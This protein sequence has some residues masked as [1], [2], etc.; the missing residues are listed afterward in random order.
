MSTAS[1]SNIWADSPWKSIT[2]GGFP[3][4]IPP[5]PD[6]TYLDG[7]LVTAILFPEGTQLFWC[8]PRTGVGASDDRHLKRGQRVTAF[9]ATPDTPCRELDYP[10]EVVGHLI[11]HSPVR[12]APGSTVVFVGEPYYEYLLDGKGGRLDEPAA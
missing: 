1:P 7:P 9:R 5:R 11:D 4:A 10:E 8:D 6:L 2:Q 3:L 12:R